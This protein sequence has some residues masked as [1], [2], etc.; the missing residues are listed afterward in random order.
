VPTFKDQAIALVKDLAAAGRKDPGVVLFDAV[1]QGNR[2][3]HMFLVERWQARSA[4]DNYMASEPT[5]T[6]R[7]KLLPLQGALYDE[8]LYE[9]IR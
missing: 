9:A 4:F 5:R 6:F 1:Q 7:A 3:N 2:P 8:R